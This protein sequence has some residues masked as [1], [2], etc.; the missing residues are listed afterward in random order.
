MVQ[1]LARERLSERDLPPG[2]HGDGAV[3]IED[4]STVRVSNIP[5]PPPI[6]GEMT[7]PAGA[8]LTQLLGDTNSRPL[9]SQRL[10][11]LRMEGRVIE[12]LAMISTSFGFTRITHAVRHPEHL[13]N[14]RIL[15]TTRPPVQAPPAE[16]MNTIG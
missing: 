10:L 1:I 12:V 4:P 9:S 11:P 8:I 3:G 13:V 15:K 5:G 16:R 6:L 2:G 14:I 7:E